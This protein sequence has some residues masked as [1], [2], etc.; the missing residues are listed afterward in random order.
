MMP[1]APLALLRDITGPCALE[2][3]PNLPA[4]YI[5]KAPASPAYMGGDSRYWPLRFTLNGVCAA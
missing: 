5:T 4:D 3:P 1:T 2:E